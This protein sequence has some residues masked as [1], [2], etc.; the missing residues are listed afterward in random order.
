MKVYVA[1]SDDAHC[2]SLTTYYLRWSDYLFP[3]ENKLQ[4]NIITAA[5]VMVP[6]FVYK[7]TQC[8]MYAEGI[9]MNRIMSVCLYLDY[10]L[11]SRIILR[12]LK[13]N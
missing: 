9:H 6:A 5:S 4:Q 3:E 11:C 13:S 12:Q 8:S 7:C 1:E 10:Y 2:I